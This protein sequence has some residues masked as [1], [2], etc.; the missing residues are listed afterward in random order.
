MVA[1]KE[2]HAH[3]QQKLQAN[4]SNLCILVILQHVSCTET[5]QATIFVSPPVW[6]YAFSEQY[7]KAMMTGC[8]Q[9]QAQLFSK[10]LA[11]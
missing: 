9:V 3:T 6:E 11:P 4:L 1:L 8:F 5:V 7:G 10:P 2:T